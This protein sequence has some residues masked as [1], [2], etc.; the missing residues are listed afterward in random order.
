MTE[1]SANNLKLNCRDDVSSWSWLWA[2]TRIKKKKEKEQKKTE[3]A[4]ISGPSTLPEMQSKQCRCFEEREA[5]QRLN[6]WAGQRLVRQQ[7]HVDAV[8]PKISANARHK[9]G[10]S[11]ALIEADMAAGCKQQWRVYSAELQWVCVSKYISVHCSWAARS[12]RPSQHVTTVLKST[13]CYW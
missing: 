5:S 4:P 2:T 12:H 6:C 10:R 3:N 9:P 11:E 8:I 1:C 13:H 7:S